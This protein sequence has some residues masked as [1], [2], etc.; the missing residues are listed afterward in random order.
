MAALAKEQG[1]AVNVIG[2][3][4]EGIPTDSGIREVEHI[5]QAGGGISQIVYAKQLSQTVQMVTRQAMTQTIKGVVNQE[6]QL[7]LGENETIDDLSPEKRGKVMEV[8]DD[9]GETMDL[10]VVILVDTSASMKNKLPTVQ[11][12]LLDLS[13]S[14]NSRMGS[15]Q[16]CL[17]TFPG[18]RK[19][20]EKALSWTPK[21]NSLAVFFLSSL[22]EELLLLGQQLKI[23]IEKFTTSGRRRSLMA[24]DE[25]Q[26]LE[27]SGR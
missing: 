12:A 16:F 23:A 5:A 15:N 25:K 4:D 11:E 8:V 14:L 26:L 13:I 1:I 10:D 7:I 18:K 27:E 2:V 20:A 9:L 24:G 21:I 17:Y 6:L 3:V 19:L 22:Q